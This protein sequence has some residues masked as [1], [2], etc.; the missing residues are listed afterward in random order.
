ML[1]TYRVVSPIGVCGDQFPRIVD[2]IDHIFDH[3]L[4]APEL[5]EVHLGELIRLKCAP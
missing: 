3:T 4:F 5:L 1:K 2:H